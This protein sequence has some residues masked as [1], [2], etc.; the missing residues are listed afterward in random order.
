MVYPK[1]TLVALASPVALACTLLSSPVVAESKATTAI[2]EEVLVTA[3]KRSQ[4]E[5]LQDVPV[6]VT[7][8]SD[9]QLKVLGF[10][11]VLDISFAIPNV[12][13]EELGT[14]RGI[15][16]FSVRGLSSTSSIIS[17]DPAVATF[18]DGVYLPSNSG[19]VLDSFDLEA[20]E[21]LRG[22]QGTLFGRNVTGGAVLVRSKRPSQEMDA[23]FISRAETG[24]ENPIYTLGIAAGGPLSDTVSARI[25]AYYKDD[26]GYFKNSAL[27]ADPTLAVPSV[28]GAYDNWQI[29]T[30]LLWEPSENASLWLKYEHLELDGAPP[31][32]QN[33]ANFFGTDDDR[34]SLNFPGGAGYEVDSVVAEL[35]WL[36]NLGTLTNITGF[37]QQESFGSTDLDGTRF[38]RFH[39]ATA[40]E[41]D[42]FSNEL[43]FAGSSGDEKLDFTFG[44]F[45]YESELRY[46]EQ[47]HIFGG[48]FFAEGGGDQE[49]SSIAIFTE[50]EYHFNDQWSALFGLRYSDEEK[51]IDFSEVAGS[52]CEGVTSFPI[53]SLPNCVV[54]SS[55]SESWQTLGGKL[56]LLYRLNDEV[57]FYSH[58]TRGFRSGGFN[59]RDTVPDGTNPPAYDEE[60]MNVFELGVKAD[61]LENRLRTNLAFFINDAKDLQRD[62]SLPGG[63]AGVQQTTA[64]TA[65]ATIT[66][67]EF[68]GQW[69]AAENL[70]LTLGFGYLDFQYDNVIYDLNNDGLVNKADEGQ[71]FPRL[72]QWTAHSSITYDIPL[73]SGNISARLSY[74]YRDDVV[75]TDSNF[76]PILDISMVNA[77]LAYQFSDD[78]YEIALYG[79]NLLD[80]YRVLGSS[81]APAAIT[82]PDP[83]FGATDL[84]RSLGGGGTFSPLATGRQIGIEFSASL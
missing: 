53:T 46:V 31:P 33:Q 72:A 73:E 56:G 35:N 1:R 66:G 47:R 41:T 62:I 61:L 52:N 38:T 67:L 6:A 43:R 80:E 45:Y 78:R 19:T 64:N 77:R 4:A 10:N 83:F 59:V 32:S 9:E 20:V 42:L 26:Q 51:D 34:V 79:K 81:A 5:A 29:R 65:D 11:S 25:S 54:T 44:V 16:S 69:L 57:Q 74:D 13:L 27:E 7:A 14:Y 21:V 12:S 36:F 48:A 58:F 75:F 68:E 76:T 22:P 24:G 17:I 30:S 40:D 39:A 28:L 63:A 3:R 37:R 50:N 60:E 23:E 18:V 82:G 70:L 2:M 84:S 49:T 55:D 8:F 15:S 71:D